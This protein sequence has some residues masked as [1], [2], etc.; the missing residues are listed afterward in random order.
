MSNE[1]KYT[2]IETRHLD[3][4]DWSAVLTDGPESA[5]YSSNGDLLILKYAGD[6]PDFIFTITGDSVGLPEYTALEIEELISQD[7]MWTI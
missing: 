6:Q 2:I 5:M 4:V 1:I 7:R 3:T